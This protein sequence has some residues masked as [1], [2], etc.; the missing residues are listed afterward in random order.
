M[1]TVVVSR[2]DE[3]I[4]AERLMSMFQFVCSLGSSDVRSVD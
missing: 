4:L 1:M 3:A 2:S